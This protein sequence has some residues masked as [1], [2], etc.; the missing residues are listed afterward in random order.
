MS[1]AAPYPHAER[2]KSRALIKQLDDLT[3]EIQLIGE[4]KK[5]MNSQ[6]I[7]GVATLTDTTDLAEQHRVLSAMCD[8]QRKGHIQRLTTLAPDDLTAFAEVMSPAEPPPPHLIWVSE[9]M[10]E[11]ERGDRDRLM[12]SMPP[13]HAKDLDVE[14]RV[15]MGD[16]TWKR[17]GDICV[18]EDVI[19]IHGRPREVLAVHEQGI[20]PVLKIRTESGRIVRAHPDHLFYTSDE[21]VKAADL[22]PGSILAVPK[23]YEAKDATTRSLDEFAF[24]G[25]LLARLIAKGSAHAKF[26]HLSANFRT[27]D[28][29][30]LADVKAIAARL[31]FNAVQRQQQTYKMRCVLVTFD[32]PCRD[33]MSAADLP[34][35]VKTGLRI[36]DW[37]FQGSNEKIAAFVGA[38]MSCHAGL[39]PKRHKQSGQTLKI[40]FRIRDNHLLAAQLQRLFQRLGVNA[41]LNEPRYLFENMTKRL[42]TNLAISTAYDQ[43]MVARR[44]RLIGANRKF[45]GVPLSNGGFV[46]PDFHEDRIAAIEPDGETQ[47]RCLT[48]EEDSSFL[49]EGL[50]VHNSTYASRYYPAWYLGRKERRIYLQAG[51]SKDFARTEFGRKTKD[52]VETDAYRQIF[53]GVGVRFD[54]KAADD[55]ILTNGNRYVTKGVGEG[56]SGFRSTNNAVDD[57]YKDYAAAQS[58]VQR[59]KIWDWFVNDFMTRL[60]PQGNAF[61]ISTRWHIDDLIG[62]LQDMGEAGDLSG[63]P[64]DIINLPVFC[65][66]PD[67]DPLGRALD[68]PIWPDFYTRATLLRQKALSSPS[69]WACLYEGNPI[70]DEGQIIKKAWLTPR[71][72]TP[73]LLRAGDPGTPGHNGGPALDDEDPSTLTGAGTLPPQEGRGTLTPENG[74]PQIVLIDKAPPFKRT[75]VSVDSAEKDT[76]RADYTA[77]TVWREAIDGRHYLVD[78]H[79]ERMEFPRLLECVEAYA[80]Q[81]NAQYVLMEEK[82]AGNQYIQHCAALTGDAVMPFAVVPINPGRDGKIFR[83]DSV[84]P[85]FRNLRVVLPERAPWLA[86]FER[87]LL[88]FPGG[89]NDDY[90]DTVSQYLKFARDTGAVRRGT[91]KMKTR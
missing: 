61:I 27:S 73:P 77:I 46:H 69:N 53:P 60:L 17:L 7:A 81:W 72:Q 84:T 36:P 3:S 21:W 39:K 8:V 51:H 74:A 31:G 83:M 30:I 82:G 65:T 58:P 2:V 76:Q 28:P 40:G 16:G 45:W 43:L 4:S 68:E 79:R 78:A 66:D 59:K 26:N 42:I 34:P 67:N 6:L 23:N 22:E 54:A 52:L 29:A 71:Y 41:R 35:G 55:W 20:R 70:P 64:W 19:T 47:T 57:P 11:I 14:T 25:Y 9:R 90:P 89:K 91:K 62:R 10:M 13:G 24:A 50:V 38:V 37:V 63:Q 87:E 33:W 80:R 86:H 15:M 44:I 5:P 56:I 49:A 18:G 48:V 12:L 88:M 1:F 75:V 85:F 32:T